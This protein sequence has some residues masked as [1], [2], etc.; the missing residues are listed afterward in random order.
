LERIGADCAPEED[1]VPHCGGYSFFQVTD[2]VEGE[3]GKLSGNCSKGSRS[4]NPGPIDDTRACRE[5][6]KSGQCL[7]RAKTISMYLPGRVSSA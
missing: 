1:G 7:V 4:G 3:R 2:C 6:H 5:M